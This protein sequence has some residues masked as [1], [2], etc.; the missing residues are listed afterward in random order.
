[1]GDAGGTGV[2]DPQE[3]VDQLFGAGRAR[4]VDAVTSTKVT[5]REMI[6]VNG[7][8]VQLV[9]EDGEALKA[10]LLAGRLPDQALVNRVLASVLGAELRGV[11]KV[12]SNLTMTSRVTTRDTLTVHQNGR[13]VDERSTESHLDTSLHGTCADT[14]PPISTPSMFSSPP[15]SNFS[16]SSTPSSLSSSPS[17]RPPSR[18]STKS[19]SPYTAA[20]TNTVTSTP[21]SARNS[22]STSRLSRSS[23]SSR[24]KSKSS[25]SLSPD[26]VEAL[27]RTSLADHSRPKNGEYVRLRQVHKPTIFGT[28]ADDHSPRDNTTKR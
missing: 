19:P 18:N 10:A 27:T 17:P 16:C 25:S 4:V 11:T 26:L 20:T 14:L 21:S 24:G 12:E 8:P 15:T 5:E 6:L 22:P 7:V 13:I 2:V 28:V 1:M 3:A 23:S 9:G